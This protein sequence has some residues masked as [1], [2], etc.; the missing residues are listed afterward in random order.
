ME[1]VNGMYNSG[2]FIWSYD[3]ETSLDKFYD[4]GKFYNVVKPMLFY[5]DK[6]SGRFGSFRFDFRCEARFDNH[7]ASFRIK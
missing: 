4:G 1:H 5:M 3:R 2:C 7:F 6:N